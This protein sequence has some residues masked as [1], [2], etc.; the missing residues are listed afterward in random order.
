MNIKELELRKETLQAIMK[1]EQVSAMLVSNN[2]NMFYTTG[3]IIS[4]YVFIPAEGEVQQFVRKPVGLDGLPGVVYVRRFEDIKDHVSEAFLSQPIMMELDGSTYGEIARFRKVFT[5]EMKNA[6]AA[7]R[8]ARA[9][10]TPYEQELLRLS[11]VNHVKSYQTIPTLFKRGMTDVDLSIEIEKA[12]RQAGCLGIFR[13]AG[14]SM[15]IFFGSLL[16]GDN[17]DNPSPYDFSMGGA[18]ANGTLPVGSNGTLLEE[19][20]CIMVD[21]GGNFTGYMTDTTRVYSVG[22]VK[23]ELALK[24]H[25]VSRE[26]C[27]AV[28]AEAKAGVAASEIYNLAMRIAKENGLEEYFMGHKQKASFVGHGIGLEINESP[29]LAPRSKDILQSGMVFALEPKFVIPQVGAVGVENSYIV[30]ED[31]VEC[32]T[33]SPEEIIEL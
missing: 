11:G 3:R 13:I 27:R 6:S 32:V 31:G 22:A 20:M 1:R 17:A 7:L 8:E 14:S 26:I 18:G 15:E 4:G 25:A 29:V 2:V 19:G 28:E 21:F 12:M 24:A 16:A 5:G 30:H 9:I 33:V 23:N 10:K